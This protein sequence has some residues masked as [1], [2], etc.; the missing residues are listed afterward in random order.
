MKKLIVITRSQNIP[1]IRIFRIFVLVR[2]YCFGL[3]SLVINKLIS[4][5]DIRTRD[6]KFFSNKKNTIGL[7]V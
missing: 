1:D 2:K 4:H 6:S 3:I 7:E 5:F